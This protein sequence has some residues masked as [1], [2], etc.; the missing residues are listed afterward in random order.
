MNKIIIILLFLTIALISCKNSVKSIDKIEIAKNY[1][2]ALGASDYSTIPSLL[3]DSIMSKEGDYKKSF[4]QSDYI[5]L[6]KWDSIFEPE[7]TILKIEEENGIVK[8]QISKKDK[9]ILFLHGEPIVTNEVIEFAEDK[10]KS[11]NITDYVIFDDTVFIKNRRKLLSWIEE[12]HP[13][14]NGFLYDQTIKG[15]LKYLKAIDV[16]EKEN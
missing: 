15:G 6:L 10:I 5:E 8:V 11:V 1:Y 3:N 13:E 9:R 12:N 7:Y 4:S 14:L 16:Y 2:K